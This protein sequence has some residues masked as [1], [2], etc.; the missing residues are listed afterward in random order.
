MPTFVYGFDDGSGYTPDNKEFNSK[1]ESLQKKGAKILD[2]KVSVC[3]GAER[4]EK[5]LYPTR[6]YL[7]IYEAEKP[8]L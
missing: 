3:S 1:L 4:R 7:I 2:I 5:Y 8:L 6:T